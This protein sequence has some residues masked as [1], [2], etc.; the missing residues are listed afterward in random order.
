MNDLGLSWNISD[1]LEQSQAILGY[2][3]LC[4]TI[5]DYFGLS[6]AISGYLGLSRSI[7]VSICGDINTDFRRNSGQVEAVNDLIEE[8]QL[9][10]VWDKFK[11]DFTRVNIDNLTG[12]VSNTSV[13]DHFFF[14]RKPFEL[15][16]DA[17]T[18]HSIENKSDHSPVYCVLKCINIEVDISESARPAPKPSWKRAS[19]EDKVIYRDN[20][21]DL[22]KYIEVPNSVKSCK[23]VK[24][25]DP[26][27][28]QDIDNFTVD[29][30]EAVQVATDM[31]LPCP[32]AG[33]GGRHGGH[34]G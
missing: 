32:A 1:Y 33:Q 10:K 31:S 27:H 29:V 5:S 16:I 7:S 18:I 30:L 8:L 17:G 23:E 9:D 26:N 11:V 21:E 28:H 24:C 4:R 15:A 6:R 13:I 12:N 2:L 34:G 14:S 20:L 3:G 25:R 19:P 22:L